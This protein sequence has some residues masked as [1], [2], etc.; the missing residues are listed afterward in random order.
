MS[1]ST[2]KDLRQMLVQVLDNEGGPDNGWY[3]YIN[4]IVIFISILT[5]VAELRFPSAY[6]TYFEYF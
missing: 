1:T 2:R 5:L 3:S 4:I 6:E